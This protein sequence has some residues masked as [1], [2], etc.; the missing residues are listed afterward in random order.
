[1]AELIVVMDG[2]QIVDVGTQADLLVRCPL[3]V[4]L[5]P[6]CRARAR[7]GRRRLPYTPLYTTTGRSRRTM[8]VNSRWARMTA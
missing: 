7:P 3:F 5:Y 4:A 1:M 6:A 2:G 8:R